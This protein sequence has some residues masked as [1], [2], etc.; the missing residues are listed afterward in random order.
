MFNQKPLDGVHVGD[1]QLGAGVVD[2]LV[3]CL[4]V[5]LLPQLLSQSLHR[6]SL[7]DQ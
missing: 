2:E 3:D 4:V 6:D 1:H 7:F 5:E